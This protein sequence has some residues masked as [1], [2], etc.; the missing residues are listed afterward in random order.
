MEEIEEIMDDEDRGFTDQELSDTL[1]QVVDE[2][3]KNDTS[4]QYKRAFWY[5]P[6]AEGG[7]GLWFGGD[8]NRLIDSLA[9]FAIRPM[10]LYLFI[11][12]VKSGS[13]KYSDDVVKAVGSIDITPDGDGY[14]MCRR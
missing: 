14:V 7:Y 11:N 9:I 4:K 10:S 3:Y 1:I 5:G 13:K 12:S 6:G 2:I 8:G